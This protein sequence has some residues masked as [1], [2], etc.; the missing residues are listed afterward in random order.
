[1]RIRDCGGPR[2]PKCSTLCSSCV[3]HG[4]V[5]ACN[6]RTP[7][8]LVNTRWYLIAVFI[9]P[10]EYRR[11]PFSFTFFPL[12]FFTEGRTLFL[13]FSNFFL[14][15]LLLTF[16]LRFS[17]LFFSSPLSFPFLSFPFLF[18]SF[19]F[20]SFLSIERSMR[21]S[22][23]KISASFWNERNDKTFH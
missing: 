8:S 3:F 12:F 21:I 15:P 14:L 6:H 23:T 17:P 9:A 1:M 10:G 13:F 7:R 20:L 18:L 22:P 11:C 16:S 2:S 19:P 4:F 5:L